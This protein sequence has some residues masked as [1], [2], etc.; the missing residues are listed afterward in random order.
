MSSESS[1]DFVVLHVEDDDAAAYLFQEALRQ[2]CG[3]LNLL[4]V[5]DG[6]RCLAFVRREGIYEGA[7]RPTLIVL[8]VNLPTQSGLQVLEVLSRV[9]AVTGIPVVVFTSSEDRRQRNKALS[10]GARRVFVKREWE[11]F[12]M[13]AQFVRQ[14]VAHHAAP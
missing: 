2:V 5:A 3:E 1:L 12:L 6:E 8:D 9:D 11:S 14:A 13:V 10:L 7:P 4:R